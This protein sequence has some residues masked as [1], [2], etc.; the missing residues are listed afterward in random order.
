VQCGIP[1]GAVM[2]GTERNGGL[3]A[4]KGKPKNSQKSLLQ[5]HFVHHESHFQSPGVESGSLR[6]E[7]ASK[8]LRPDQ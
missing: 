5:C 7:P 8:L 2:D 1:H 4:G 6:Q 3:I